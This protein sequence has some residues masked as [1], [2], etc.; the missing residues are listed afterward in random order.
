ML[1]NIQ[2]AAGI[3]EMTED[4]VMFENQS[5]NLPAH[6]DEEEMIWQFEMDDVLILKKE[7]DD[8]QA[9]A[10]LEKIVSEFPETDLEE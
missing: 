6:I 4:E 1:I 2:Y 9:A 3:L 10:E 5:G 8:A 7:R